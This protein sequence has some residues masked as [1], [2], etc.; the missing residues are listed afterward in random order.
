MSSQFAMILAAT[1]GFQLNGARPVIQP[2]VRAIEP[3]MA[4][5]PERAMSSAAAAALALAL[6]AANPTLTHATIEQPAVVQQYGG[7]MV[8]DAGEDAALREAQAKFLAERAALKQTYEAS[9][10]PTFT[11]ADET[12]DKKSVY[13]TIV[14]GLV[15]IAFLAPM[16][17]FF[18][19]TGGE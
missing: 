14:A 12:R 8:A 5:A 17:Q 2:V 3:Q 10:D 18:Y 7:S 1:A 6:S 9:T 15:G 19:Y 13:V 4:L 11:S 16:L